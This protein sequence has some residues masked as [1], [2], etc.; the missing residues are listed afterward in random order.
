MLNTRNLFAKF[1]RNLGQYCHQLGRKP[2]RNQRT[3]QRQSRLAR[4]IDSLES[5]VLLTTTITGGAAGSPIDLTNSLYGGS[6]QTVNGELYWVISD[7]ASITIS[8]YCDY[9]STTYAGGVLFDSPN[10]TIDSAAVITTYG[11]NITFENL[12]VN[13]YGNDPN[14]TGA[15]RVNLDNIISI[16]A[17][18][19]INTS[20]QSGKGGDITLIAPT[21]D[22]QDCTT[23]TVTSLIASGD[24]AEDDGSIKLTSLSQ[25]K[26]LNFSGDLN[27]A[28]AIAG[29][30]SE[31]F[32]G[33]KA[34]ITV[35]ENVQL[36]GGKVK[37]TAESGNEAIGT[38]YTGTAAFFAPIIMEGL[39]KPDLFSLP[40]AIQIWKPTSSITI[41]DGATINSTG[42]VIIES[43]ATA[44]AIGKAVFNSVLTKGDGRLGF[45]AGFFL[46]QATATIDL[47]TAT[48]SAGEEVELTTS[49]EN[50]AELEVIA[51]KNNSIT[52]TNP[53]AIDISAG[54]TE[55]TTVSTITM[56]QQSTINAGGSVTIAAEATDENKVSVQSN[57]YRDGTVGFAGASAYTTANVQAIINGT[58]TSGV[59]AN[60]DA[61]ATA[62][63]FNPAYT[64]NFSNSTL[65]FPDPV[66]FTTGD[67]VYYQSS[68]GSSIP[69]LI[70]GNVYFAI[71]N[72][73]TPDV[74]QLATTKSNATSNQYINFGAGFP[75]LT[76]TTSGTTSGSAV[77]ITAILPDSSGNNCLLF[78]YTTGPDGKTNVLVNGDQVVYTPLA[79]QAISY[80]DV[81]G[82]LLGLLPAGTYTVQVETSPEPTL[83][84]L[85]IRLIDGSGNLVNLNTNSFL[86]ITSAT[87][88]GTAYQI[89]SLSSANSQLTLNSSSTSTTGTGPTIDLSQLVNGTPLIFTQGLG[90]SGTGLTDQQTYYAVVDTTDSG[91]IRLAQSAPQAAAANPAVQDAIPQLLT[92]NNQ[93]FLTLATNTFPTN[94]SNSSQPE[95]LTL[96][97]QT[98]NSYQL[99]SNATG[100]TFTLNVST[101]MDLATPTVTSSLAYNVSSSGLAAALNAVTG[102]VATV[103]GSGTQSDPWIIAGQFELPIGTFEEGVGLVFDYNPGLTNGSPV[104]YQP[105]AGKPMSGFSTT[106]TTYYAYRATNPNFNANLPQY[107]LSLS[108]SASTNTPTPFQYQ[109]IMTDSQGLQYTVAGY[110]A[111]QNTLQLNLPELVQITPTSTDSSGLTG[112]SL[113]TLVGGA[114]P[115][116]QCFSFATSG[117]FTLT[118]TGTGSTATQTTAAIAWNADANTLAN[119]LNALTSVNVTVTGTGQIGSPWIITGLDLDAVTVDSSLLKDGTYQTNLLQQ[120]MTSSFSQLWTTATGGTFSL[121]LNVNGVSETLSTPLAYNATAATVQSA[122]NALPGVR[123]SVSGSG[124]ATAPWQITLAYLS[125]Q[126]GDA[127]TFTD[128]WSMYNMGVQ[129]GQTCYAVITASQTNSL[130]LQLQLAT[131]QAEALQSTPAVVQMPH[132]LLFTAPTGWQMTGATESLTEVVADSGISITADLQSVD[133]VTSSANLGLFPMLAYYWSQKNGWV[134][135]HDDPAKVLPKD[136]KLQPIEQKLHDHIPNGDDKS[137]DFELAASVAVLVVKN[138]VQA[139]IG[140]TATLIASGLVTVESTLTEV[141]HSEATASI[142]KPRIG[143]SDLA[144]AIALNLAFIDNTSQAIIQSN[145]NVTGATGVDIQST[146]TYPFAL[147]QTNL[148]KYAH[149]TLPATYKNIGTTVENIL[150]TVM[151]GNA[152][153]VSNWLFN[154]TANVGIGSED[155]KKSDAVLK[156]AVSLSCS[157]I[158][159]NNTNLAQIEDGAQIN[160]SKDVIPATTQS[161]KIVANTTVYQTGVTGMLYLGLNVGWLLYTLKMKAPTSDDWFNNLGTVNSGKNSLGGSFGY[162]AIQNNTQALLG[163]TAPGEPI[164]N[165]TWQQASGPTNV[166][167]GTGSGDLEVSANTD[168]MNVMLVQGGGKSSEFGFDGSFGLIDMGTNGTNPQTQTTTAQI[169]VGNYGLNLQNEGGSI[170]ITVNDDTRAIV[171]TG[172]I[173]IGAPKNIGFSGSLIYL[174]RD[175]YAGFGTSTFDSTSPGITTGVTG[176]V[177]ISAT[178]TGKIIPIALVGEDV[179]NKPKKPDAPAG[180]DNANAGVDGAASEAKGTWGLGVSGD[181]SGAWID[182][183]V[184]AWLVDS[185]TFS[186][187]TT[188]TLQVTSENL[189]Q[190]DAI[191][192]SATIVSTGGNA[193]STVAAAGSASIVNYDSAVQ[194]VVGYATIAAYLLTVKADNKKTIGSFS[195]GMQVEAVSS[196]TFNIDGS[197]AYNTVKNTTLAE[198][199]NMNPAATSSFANSLT[200]P[201]I[202]ATTEDR[203]WAAAG[204]LSFTYDHTDA[205][206]PTKAK[207]VIGVG[208]SGAMNTLTNSTDALILN[209]TLNDVTGT[210]TVASNDFS[211]SFVFSS[212]VDIAVTA[213]IDINVGGMFTTTN[214]NPTSLAKIQGS[215]ITGNSATSPANIALS[216]EFVPVAMSI[217]GYTAVDFGKALSTKPAISVGVGAGVVVTKITGSIQAEV[218]DSTIKVGNGAVTVNSYSGAPETSTQDPLAKLGTNNIYSLAIAG[219][220]QGE[221]STDRTAGTIGIVGAVIETTLAL[222][223]LSNVISQAA[224]TNIMAGQVAVTATEN[225]QVSHDAGGAVLAGEMSSTSAVGVAVGGGAGSYHSTDTVAAWVENSTVNAT[226]SLSVT[227]LLETTTSSIAFGV[228]VE[229]AIAS[230]FSGAGSLSGAGFGVTETNTI[231][232]YVTGGTLNV[233]SDG[234]NTATLTISATDASK[235]S[236]KSG[237]G[238][239]AVAAGNSGVAIAPSV[240]G[241]KI[242]VTN[243]IQAYLGEL[244]STATTLTSVNSAV[245]LVVSAKAAETNESLVIAVAA[246][247]SASEFGG[248]LAYSEA[249]SKITSTNTI[250]AQIGYGATITST[251]ATAAGNGITVEATDSNS[252]TAKVGAGGLAVALVG[253]SL[254]ISTSQVDHYDTTTAQITGATVTTAGT[255][256]SVTST[257]TNTLTSESVPVSASLALGGAGAGGNSNITDNSSV[258][259][260]I[261]AGASIVTTGPSASYGNLSVTASS[262]DTVTA[263]IYAGVGGLGSIGAFFSTVT[264]AASAET[265]A[266][267]SNPKKINV[268]SLSV[269][270]T[271]DQSLTSDGW[272]ITIGVLA[273]TGESHTV[274]NQETVTA[275][276]TDQLGSTWTAAGNVQVIATCNTTTLATNS[277]QGDTQSINIAGLGV[278][279]YLTTATAEPTVTAS[280]TTVDLNAGSNNLT[281][282]AIADISNSARTLSGSG[283]VVGGDA[284]RTTTTNSPVVA[285]NISGS[286]TAAF[287]TTITATSN[288]NYDAYAD[289]VSATVIGGSGARVTNTSSPSTIVTLETNG[290]DNTVIS[291]VGTVVIS[292]SN[293]F[294][295][296]ANS[297]DIGG[298]MVRIGAGGGI[299]GYGG[300]VNSTVTPTS[301]VNINENVSIT[302]SGYGTL[303]PNANNG[304]INISAYQ[305][306]VDNETANLNTGGLVTGSSAISELTTTINTSVTIGESVTIQSEKGIVGIGTAV[307]MNT[308]NAA[309]TK[310]W[311]LGGAAKADAGVSATVNQSVQ[312]G[313]SATLT[314]AKAVSLT[315]GSIPMNSQTSVVNVLAVA[316]STTSGL[317]VVPEATASAT[318]T[319]APTLSLGSLSSVV[320]GGNAVIGATPGVV[321]ATEVEQTVWDGKSQVSQGGTSTGSGAVTLDGKVTAGTYNNLA[322][323]V[324]NNGQSITVNNQTNSISGN[325]TSVNNTGSASSPFFDFTATYNSAYAPQYTN[326]ASP[327]LVNLVNSCLSTETVTA[328]TLS[329]LY[330]S[331]GSVL[332]T[333][334]SISGSGT[335]TAQQPSITITNP[336]AAYLILDG[337]AIPSTAGQGQVNLTNTTGTVLASGDLTIHAAG[338]AEPPITVNQ[339]Y[340]GVVGNPASGSGG[341]ALIVKNFLNNPSGSVSLTNADGPNVLGAAVNAVSFTDKSPNSAF[342][343]IDPSTTSL[344]GSGGTTSDLLINTYTQAAV[345]PSNINGT[346]Y[347]PN[348]T[349]PS[350]FFYPGYTSAA[351][352]NASLAATAAVDYLY[353][354]T[355]T[356]TGGNNLNTT[357][358]MLYFLESVL[359]NDAYSKGSVNSKT[360]SGPNTSIIPFSNSIPYYNMSNGNAQGWNDQSGNVDSFANTASGGIL[361][362]NASSA[363]QLG[364]TSGNPTSLGYL[365]YILPDQPIYAT[366]NLSP[367]TSTSLS[368]GLTAAQVYIEAGYIDINSPINVGSA[369]NLNLVLSASLGQTLAGYRSTYVANPTSNAEY[370]ITADLADAPAGVTASYNAQTQQ[371]TLSDIAAGAATVSCLLHGKLM[372][373]T[374]NGQINMIGGSGLNSITN[375]TGMA[376]VL[377][378][379]S[380]GST[381]INATV[382][383]QDLQKNQNTKYVYGSEN[384]ITTYTTP[385]V[386]SNGLSQVY[387]AAPVTTAATSATYS[388]TTGQ[389]YSWSD[390]ANISRSMNFT[391]VSGKS[392]VTSASGSGV[393][394]WGSNPA[395]A[396]PTTTTNPYTTGA[397]VLGTGYTLPAGKTFVEYL[398]ASQVSSQSYSGFEFTTKGSGPPYGMGDNTAWNYIYPTAYA[399]TLQTYIKA[400]NPITI[401]FGG[402]TQGGLLVQSDAD[403]LLDGQI[404]FAG[405][406][407]I[408]SE[409]QIEQTATGSIVSKDVNLVGTM[410]GNSTTPLIVS[411]EGTNGITALGTNGVY[412][413]SGSGGNLLVDTVSATGPATNG[414]ATTGLVIDGF[415]QGRANWSTVNNSPIVSGFSGFTT[416]GNAQIST[417]TSLSLSQNLNDQ[418]SAAW[419]PTKVSTG[420]FTTSFTYTPSGAMAADGIALVF[421]NEGTAA[422]GSDGGY[423]GYVGIPGNTAAYQMNIYAGHVVGTNFITDNSSFS[424]NSTGGVAINSGHPIHVSLTFNQT[425][426]TLTENLTDTQTGVTYQHVYDNVNLYSLLGATAYLGFTGGTGGAVSIQ[427]ITNFQFQSSLPQVMGSG[428]EMTQAGIGNQTSAIWNQT[429]VD[430][431]QSF[432]TSFV[433]QANGKNPADGVAL[434]FQTQGTNVI[435]NAGGYLGYQGIA[436]NSAAYQINIYEGHTQGTNFILHPASSTA[437]MTM[438]YNATG[439]VNV[440]SGNP[441]RVKLHYDATNQTITEDLTDLTTN[442]TYQH[443]YSGVNLG[444]IASSAYIGFTGADGGA[445]ALQTI[446]AFRFAY[447]TTSTANVV[448]T[449]AKNITMAHPDS[450]VHGYQVTLTAS[451]GSI[452]T[453]SSPILLQTD[454]ARLSNGMLTGGTV[455]ATAGGNISLQQATGD[456][457]L[458]TIRAT[459][460]VSLTNTQGNIVDA[461]TPDISGVNTSK[462]SQQQLEQIITALNTAQA[463]AVNETVT[464]YEQ[465]INSQYQ[466]YWNLFQ[467]GSVQ[468]GLFVV[469]QNSIVGLE[470][471]VAIAMNIPTATPTDVQTYENNIY[472]N[473]VSA[474]ATPQ[475]FGPNWATLSQFQAYNSTYQ[476]TASS[477]TV[478][479]FS[480]G[481]ESLFSVTSNLALEAL[482]PAGIDNQ[483][484]QTNITA[485]NLIL[486]ASGSIGINNQPVTIPLSDVQQGTLTRQQRDL[487]A[488]ATTSGSV[489]MVGSNAQGDSMQYQFGSTPPGY[490][491]TGVVVTVFRPVNVNIAATGTISATTTASSSSISLTQDQGDMNVTKI[492]TPGAVRLTAQGDIVDRNSATTPVSSNVT[493]SGFGGSGTGWTTKSNGA[494][495]PMISNNVLTLTSQYSGWTA[496][497][498]WNNTPVLSTEP[499][500]ASFTYSTVNA[501]AD[502]VAFV[503]QN[504]P[505]GTNALGAYGGGVGYSGITQS[506]AFVLDIYN[507]TAM[508][509]GKNGVI[510]PYTS[511]SPVNIKS[512][513]NINVVLNYNPTNQTLTANLTDTYTGQTYSNTTTNLNLASNVGGNQMFLGFTGGDGGATSTQ[514]ISNFSYTSTKII[515]SPTPTVMGTTMDLIAG[516]NIGE[517]GSSLKTAASGRVNANALGN[518]SVN[519]LAG[520]LNIGQVITSGTATL[521]AGGSIV[522]DSPVASGTVGFGGTGTGWTPKSVNGQISIAD[523]TL[524]LINNSNSTTPAVNTPS[525]NNAIWLNSPLTLQRDFEANFVYQSSSQNGGMAITLR[526][527]ANANATTSTAGTA[528][529]EP[530]LAFFMNLGNATPNSQT[531]G[532]NFYDNNTPGYLPQNGPGYFAQ[533]SAPVNL[534]SNHPINVVLSYSKSSQTLFA[535]LTDTITKQVTNFSQTTIDLQPMLG[536]SQLQ[537]G[538]VSYSTG[539]NSTTQTVSKFAFN[540]GVTAISAASLNAVAGGSFGTSSTP[541]SIQISGEFQGT[542]PTGIYAIQVLN[543]LYT[544]SMVSSG[545]VSL[546]APL[547]SILPYTNAPAAAAPMMAMGAPGLGAPG[548]GAP[549]PSFTQSSAPGETQGIHAPQIELRAL[550]SVGT[551]GQPLKTFTGQLQAQTRWNDV[552]ITNSGLLN[553]G[554]PGSITGGISAGESVALTNDASII[555]NSAVSANQSISLSSLGTAG[556]LAQVILGA[557]ATVLAQQ[558]GISLFG[559][560]GIQT[561][562]TSVIKSLGAAAKSS[563]SLVTGTSDSQTKNNSLVQLLGQL[564][565]SSV[566]VESQTPLRRLQLGLTG[567]QGT[568]ALPASVKVKGF[569]EFRADNSLDTIG[570]KISLSHQTL[571]LQRFNVALD[572]INSMILSAGSGSDQIAVGANTGVT[573]LSIAGNGGN[574]QFNVSL[575]DARLAN[576]AIDGGTGSDAMQV[577]GKGQNAWASQGVVQT[578]LNKVN[579]TGVEQLSVTGSPAINGLAAR[580][581]PVDQ[582][583]FTNLTDTQKYVMTVFAQL[584]HRDPT[585]AEFSLWT[586]RIDRR[587]VSRLIMAQQ[588]ANTIEAHTLQVQAW[589]SQY[590]GRPAT[591]KELFLPVRQLAS[592]QPDSLVLSQILAGGGFAKRVNVLVPGAAANDQFVIGL[593]K[594]AIAPLATPTAAELLR[595]TIMVRRLGRAAAARDILNSA[596]FRS[597]RGEALSAQILNKAADAQTKLDSQREI[598]ASNLKA[599]LLSRISFVTPR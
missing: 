195:G 23:S 47:Q 484:P 187:T 220:A 503:L 26:E 475:A 208:C 563:L 467:Y 162:S 568:G 592:G 399:L 369:S 474:F 128:C 224:T 288:V 4:Q 313:S 393:W 515:N 538:F 353:N 181:F 440:A 203:A 552:V 398:T 418:A 557:G 391:Q 358:T 352:F 67:P 316:S 229:V 46:N 268:G 63:S 156:W 520:N 21:I 269:T 528:A 56:D 424:Y 270:A 149:G 525:S 111:S 522:A 68:N 5:R 50:V 174:T 360:H 427:T 120:A 198:L 115:V 396:N 205:E 243:T 296:L 194:A 580:M 244:S 394:G 550:N 430:L 58:V 312:V 169:L 389:T 96:T 317:L 246:A 311:G 587:I 460:Q 482:S 423:L 561:D 86:T 127:L 185:G 447:S 89:Y 462:F 291:A 540:Y 496:N 173:L 25:I 321:A 59:A 79:G 80:N 548:L 530:V 234:P 88:A 371:I 473:C 305:L 456:M 75:T 322:I 323:S 437:P 404:L 259:S 400:D 407:Q 547:G 576:I 263:E 112:G 544:G 292:T 459:G 250:T 449:A 249:Y 413:T 513:D 546:S 289:S 569:Q 152:F 442:M 301:K 231:Q 387:P 332:V 345:S 33:L 567:I 374:S 408:H 215:T 300:S 445:Y 267:I 141:M 383:I 41:S 180:H 87:G 514:R 381:Q 126:T 405:N 559:L 375:N 236:T 165:T 192:G 555:V 531:I 343:M 17:G 500:T 2:S 533:S 188:N 527:A 480:A 329:N 266:Q 504:S 338:S 356:S 202:I 384:A 444:S 107:V 119:A 91:V 129:N 578:W 584:L 130:Q 1:I 61:A 502:G 582:A 306:V 145:A 183:T 189:T 392:A 196:P 412:L 82:N 258:I 588:L 83:F 92:L 565:G 147:T 534:S 401:N 153:G 511:T 586:K 331:G 425:S 209:S 378:G 278:G 517:T 299:T 117:T 364:N 519:Q 273:G 545:T 240:S 337:V 334:D 512:G 597:N 279:V 154:N 406:V 3:R 355:P 560:D 357:T 237:S 177:A 551:T 103:T 431:T 64:V 255:N 290:T 435:G 113:S 465:G 214:I 135:G 241:C 523:D 333:A 428:V 379:I 43:T 386:A 436:G 238:S 497:A 191:S 99:W 490:T 320:S 541:M 22:F 403:V 454:T 388:P 206:D 252:N 340:Q 159:I 498:V 110:N 157:A 40:L 16:D 524:T 571:S 455:S 265:T 344:F 271:A 438:N 554:Q 478:A 223:T 409:G 426:Q 44:T 452:G 178:A 346:S 293:E 501:V 32:G 415:Q 432:D 472:Q 262:A 570:Q 349:I 439:S 429:K 101:P 70:S 448:L 390:T 48:I 71:V 222:K 461:L 411:T 589:Y 131:S 443:Q 402:V 54:Y 239:L 276:L 377:Q 536:S 410:I 476:F 294:Q 218:V 277:G 49:V 8:G 138:N 579:H 148:W 309:T 137:N 245:P 29:F 297:A 451:S 562:P 487:L 493:I 248:A 257:G 106:P 370:D 254:G 469:N 226:N 199:I 35:G 594:L 365:P 335:L 446:S 108:S 489:I 125:I 494:F 532:C 93:S 81:N 481:S 441:I 591:A 342:V 341:P 77:P 166:Q 7:K 121:T 253:M 139:L 193:E 281:V 167:F 566:V 230:A 526:N 583:R 144:T 304:N 558:S 18:V 307:V 362:N 339:S 361:A 200:S 24:T 172:A 52:A 242:S 168:V 227:A 458:G 385:Y 596:Q 272:S 363:Y 13:Q 11:S 280:I 225:L 232:A 12:D 216:A 486:N 466:Q 457:R 14:P 286:T 104:L 319:S 470:P 100:G 190:V 90:Q 94:P 114:A 97:Q 76:K 354:S 417:S 118:V 485:G 134:N 302:S 247:V 171:A 73:A 45:A 298:Y 314:G 573:S 553:L 348:Y 109:Q 521:N 283:A 213:G 593:N 453:T 414:S 433:Y 499:F 450:L 20:S 397:Y 151:F 590:L 539:S 328:L 516:G 85:A 62:V 219:S 69:G 506:T 264:R 27:Q 324:S 285:V 197:I 143:E 15:R 326:S 395:T 158:T 179:S 598:R 318:L 416:V 434:V 507:Q 72:S 310:T 31:L 186:G 142:T 380:T 37:I 256:I 564:V 136:D 351:S 105:V 284:V 182:D 543:N 132:Y 201:S 42:A 124:T 491:T 53:K 347:T 66:A 325:A 468:N 51:I 161:V 38:A 508:A 211:H 287:N 420:S 140:S 518:L 327:A 330:A 359:Y 510:G 575:A 509:I 228:A 505:S 78:S 368:A 535:K 376:L 572:S 233:G 74:M 315:T 95:A 419:A 39:H 549:V 210:V 336:T 463:A 421:Q 123:A 483:V 295:R 274:T 175:V 581:L 160:Q 595:L 303:K 464:S 184:N 366:G 57:A 204:M 55:M 471:L 10:I 163:G 84:P 102:V 212:G 176:D 170:S 477:Q 133:S 261:S 122:L 282:E 164:K 260:T 221:V 207:T 537:L 28:E 350:T 235:N 116:F 9:D 488:L 495:T 217:A 275:A 98:N 492:Q 19:T 34:T 6:S 556:N 150:K 382:E 529:A 251:S 542:A 30:I 65:N 308:L 574:D 367:L 599:I 422:I 373:T 60:D 155:S 585:A 479:Q 146:I 36:T 372:S 577:D